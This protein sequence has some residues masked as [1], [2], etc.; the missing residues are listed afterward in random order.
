LAPLAVVSGISATAALAYTV[1]YVLLEL[2]AFG[3]VVA[4]RGSADGG[5][6]DDY[7]GAARRHPWVAGVLVLALAGL[8]GLP[9]GLAGL[10]AKVGVV[11]AL[12]EGG[13]GWLAVVLAVNA[14]VGLAYYVRAALALFAAPSPGAVW[15]RVPVGVGVTLAA[16]TI[17]V[18]VAGFAPGV[19]LT[20]S[21]M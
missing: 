5:T 1:F 9:P 21:S 6:L 20:L 2:G 15:G 17:A 12:L 3:A 11:R 8:A 7:R 4:L 18:V 16:V 19:I 13:A 14:V 10:F